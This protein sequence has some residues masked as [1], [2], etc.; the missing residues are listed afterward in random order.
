M[1]G[2][3]QPQTRSKTKQRR[4]VGKNKTTTTI[5]PTMTTTTTNNDNGNKDNAGEEEDNNKD[6][7]K[8]RHDDC[9]PAPTTGFVTAGTTQSTINLCVGKGHERKRVRQGKI[10][11]QPCIC[12]QMQCHTTTTLPTHRW[13]GERQ[14]EYVR[15]VFKNIFD[16]PLPAPRSRRPL[17][18]PL[19]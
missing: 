7:N 9:R 11:K 1:C 17:R 8:N 19:L 10:N 14:K 16:A 18:P 4:A 12:K 2:L 15:E 5:N 3:S 6:D 13:C